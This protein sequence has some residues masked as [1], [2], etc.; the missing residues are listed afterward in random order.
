MSPA[1]SWSRP[2]KTTPQSLKLSDLHSWTTI[3]LTSSGMG[4]ASFHL[5]T[6]AYCWPAERD[7]APSAW[8]L[9]YGCVERS[10]MKLL[11]AVVDHRLAHRWPTV[12]VAPRM[13]T[14]MGSRAIFDEVVFVQSKEGR[15]G[16]EK[17]ERW[18]A[19]RGERRR[20]DQS[21]SKI[22]RLR[23]SGPSVRSL[24]HCRLRVIGTRHAAY[25]YQAGKKGRTSFQVK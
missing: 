20:S 7:E 24:A 13:P 1:T 4:D 11:S 9:K 23:L 6:L 14:L 21:E 15:T 5:V 12:P 2:E 22:S 3:F 18:P 16:N 8:I 17:V 19:S 25:G 10:S